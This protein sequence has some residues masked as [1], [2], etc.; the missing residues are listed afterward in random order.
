VLNGLRDWRVQHPTATL[1][2]I[3]EEL[4]ILMAGMQDP[5]PDQFYRCQLWP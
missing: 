4:G 2:E 5:H 3:E 1:Q